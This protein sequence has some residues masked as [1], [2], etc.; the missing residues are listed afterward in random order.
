MAEQERFSVESDPS[1][2]PFWRRLPSFFVYPMQMGSL[3]RLAVFSLAGSVAILLIGMFGVFIYLIL[4]LVF[5]KYAFVVLERTANGR[6]DEPNNLD[7]NEVGE[8]GQV[9]RMIA[10]FVILGIQVV[11]LSLLGTIGEGLGWLLVNIIPPAGIMIIA[12]S[13][14]LFQALN[15]GQIFFYIRTIGSPYLALCFLLLSVTSSGA[16]MQHF[17]H[18]HTNS[19]LVVP[20]T[21]FVQFYFTLI[22]YNMMGYV[23]YQYHDKLGLHA[24]VSFE[25]AQEK[26][27]PN[28]KAGDPF[29]AK[30][31]ALIAEGKEEEACGVLREELRT[32]WE[33]N[34]LH[35]RYQKLLMATGKKEQAL[36]HALD[37]IGKLVLEKK[38]FQALDLCE[39]GLKA[40]PAFQPRNADHVYDL[41]AAASLS[42]RPKL[43]LDLMRGFDKRYPGHKHTAQVYLLSAK[44]LDE[45]Y[46]KSQEAAKI[47]RAVQAKFP[48]HAAAAEARKYLEV[49][50]R[51]DA[52]AQ[53]VG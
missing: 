35:E 16:W 25:K 39:Q 40:D 21:F 9:L 12:T 46:G 11:L 24:E 18:S 5:F 7:G 15:P 50:A 29:L 33:R 27:G 3:V 48:D 13:R 51:L 20:L 32:N 4:W 17:M 45:R 30:L 37:F 31:A 2:T 28:K 23:I 10:L 8:I 42:N 49:L 22:T 6:F 19:W 38:M 1:F 26:I 41:A 36:Q 14:S 47:L 43:A 52:A 34:D 44:I 53:K